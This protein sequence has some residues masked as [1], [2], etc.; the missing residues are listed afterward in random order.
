MSTPSMG[1]GGVVADLEL[2]EAFLNTIDERSFRRH[3]QA[4]V[5][6]ETLATL[7]DLSR[8]LADHGLAN[9]DVGLRGEDV[10]AAVSLRTGLRDTLA[11]AIDD[12]DVSV[13]LLADYPLALDVD[14]NAQLRIAG[15]SGRPW[16]DALV[17]TVSYAVA[18]G[19]WARIKL[20]AAPDCR[21]A[22]YDTSRNGRGRWCD[23]NVCGNRHK[24]RIYRERQR[25]AAS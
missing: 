12:A 24:T 9:A 3:G 5:A 19:D 10:V 14:A 11:A 1:Y 16:L 18:R 6:G 8:W 17:E 7:Q 4:H 25:T 15:R 2:I 23:M 13:G 21:W 22:F 20:C